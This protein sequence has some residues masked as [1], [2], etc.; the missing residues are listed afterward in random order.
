MIQRD[1]VWVD[2]DLDKNSHPV[3]RLQYIKIKAQ[4]T[5]MGKSTTWQVEPETCNQEIILVETSYS[6]KVQERERGMV[7]EESVGWLWD[8]GV[9]GNQKRVE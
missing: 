1:F 2:G 3:T 4:V 9:E 7:F 6:R 8:G 5:W